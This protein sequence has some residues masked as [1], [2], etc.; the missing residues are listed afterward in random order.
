M[1]VT[2]AAT[3]MACTW[4]R[5]ANLKRAESLVRDAAGR[6]AQIVLLQEL[7]ETPYFCVDELERH[8]GLASSIDEN[9]AVEWASRLATELKIVLPLTPSNSPA[10]S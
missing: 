6:G 9:S 10:S 2:V 5:D 8:Y 4:D 7:L 1:T 3:Q